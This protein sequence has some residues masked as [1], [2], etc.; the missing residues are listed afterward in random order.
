MANIEEIIVSHFNLDFDG[1][2]S[3]VAAKK[4]FPN[5]ILTIHGRLGPGLKDFASLHK[6]ALS[7][8][9]LSD[10]DLERI[11]RVII[12]DTSQINRLGVL[13]KV[14]QKE[15]VEVIIFDHHSVEQ[16]DIKYSK[17]YFSN[18]GSTVT[19]ISELLLSKGYDITPFEATT[20]LLGVYADTGRMIYPSTTF[21]DAETVAYL[22]KKGAN[23]EIIGRYLDSPLTFEQRSLLEELQR[24]SIIKNKEGIS[25]YIS[26][27]KTKSYIPG[28]SFII[29]KIEEYEDSSITILIV[30]MDSKI[31]LVGR[32]RVKNINILEILSEF[33]CK[34]HPQACSSVLN[35]RDIGQI[36]NSIFNT[37][38]EAIFT[39][40]KAKDIMTS[41]VKT[42]EVD[43]TIDEVNSIILRYGHTGL[44]VV[45]NGQLKGII[46]RRDIEKAK[47]HGLG[48]APV[49]GFMSRNVETIDRETSIDE[50]NRI[51][52]SKEIGRLPVLDRDG[53]IGIVT[54][55]DLLKYI[56]GENH[57]K[58]HQHI[59][60]QS[61]AKDIVVDLKNICEDKLYKLL[62]RT[63][64][65]A[66]SLNYNV[67]AVGGFVRDIFLNKRI[68]DIDIVVE[69]EGIKLARLVREDFDGKLTIHD[70]FQTATIVMEDGL[71][72]D[73]VTS[74]R[75]FYEY[76]AA[77]PT[78]ERSS[79][80]ND[81]LRRD[82]TV[83]SMAII[84]DKGKLGHLVDF[85]GGL[86]DLKNKKIR[87]LYNL[88]FIEDPTRIF[89]GVRFCA[90]LGFDF[91][92]QTESFLRT[93]IKQGVLGSLSPKRLTNEFIHLLEEEDLLY[94]L[95]LMDELTILAT[96]FP[97]VDV[98]G[99]LNIFKTLDRKDLV[100]LL[101]VMF[102]NVYDD[103]ENYCNKFELDSN[104]RNI[105]IGLSKLFIVEIQNLKE[106]SLTN[107]DIYILL[108]GYSKDTLE[109]A[110]ELCDNS[111]VRSRI[112][113]Y[114]NQLQKV[115]LKVN[116]EVLKNLG[117]KPGPAYKEIMGK[118]LEN[119][120]N[121]ID[122]VTLDEEEFLKYYLKG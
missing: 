33:G 39:P 59:F 78:I 11:K 20:M 15:D 28:L 17:A 42:V 55:T 84:L 118:V 109:M 93:A 68:H 51:L 37:L 70:E 92:K 101:C 62:L 116:G 25:L 44:P 75:E 66:E 53:L 121:N 69:G 110:F 40:L 29:K 102:Y 96:L 122:D 18:T 50:I 115:T 120:L 9:H 47:H 30:E 81:L 56:H 38:D 57:P 104:S 34:G 67:Y 112:S 49:K 73:F 23:L 22:L 27:G 91:E 82:F 99:S 90:R 117:I 43:M 64:E 3:M 35:H 79:I 88:S 111:L 21:R 76:P 103:V 6:D 63:G 106:E 8:Y 46:S 65:L 60:S 36:T 85:F 16:C 48:H 41:P 77:L 54:R 74:R 114:C 52:I 10:I 113:K 107:Y 58:W 2:A 71:E 87:I 97:K 100:S 31:Q 13:T 14:L 89:R 12:V 5:G 1:L 45:E 119:K 26:S 4:L 72:V 83:N 61:K 94:A 80:Y 105:I 7:L 32:S 19:I 95:D 98:K 24:N 108:K 86:T